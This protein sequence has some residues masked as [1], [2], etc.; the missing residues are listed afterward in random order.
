MKRIFI[1]YILMILTVQLKAQVVIPSMRMGGRTKKS[2]YAGGKGKGTG[3]AKKVQL[4]CPPM[5][6]AS[7][8]FGGVGKGGS[9][10]VKRQS[11]CSY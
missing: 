4:V 5:P 6:V 2:M 3:T 10:S 8:F 7:I 9:A 11:T 1:L